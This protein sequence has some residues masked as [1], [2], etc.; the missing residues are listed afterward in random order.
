LDSVCKNR[1]RVWSL[2]SV[3]VKKKTKSLLTVRIIHG[4]FIV[5]KYAYGIE[6][7]KQEEKLYV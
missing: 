1:R 6:N 4:N 7:T 2:T 3:F 5:G